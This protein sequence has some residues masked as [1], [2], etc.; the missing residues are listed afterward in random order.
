VTRS[1]LAELRAAL[2]ADSE[3]VALVEDRVH[4]GRAPDGTDQPYVVLSLI[5]EAPESTLFEGDDTTLQNSRVQV[6]AWAKRYEEAHEIERA[7]LAVLGGLR[8]PAPGLSAWKA[9]GTDLYDDEAELHGAATD[10]SVWR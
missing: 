9:A 2:L 1:L 8:A 10:F 7:I 6:T 3:M 4:A 5:S